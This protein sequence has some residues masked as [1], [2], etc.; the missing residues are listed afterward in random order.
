[1]PGWDFG[2]KTQLLVLF[3]NFCASA[4]FRSLHPSRIR[5][6]MKPSMWGVGGIF[7]EAW[8]GYL[9]KSAICS[10]IYPFFRFR[11]LPHLTSFSHSFPRETIRV[12]VGGIIY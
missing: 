10:A 8:V 1:M 6:P 3:T 2:A 4:S 11:Q 12:G 7:I 9:R 5:S